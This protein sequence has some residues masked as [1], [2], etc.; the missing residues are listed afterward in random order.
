MGYLPGLSSLQTQIEVQ[1]HSKQDVGQCH[2]VSV[3]LTNSYA[4]EDIVGVSW[5]NS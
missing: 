1:G 3:A 4:T 5:S 2:T